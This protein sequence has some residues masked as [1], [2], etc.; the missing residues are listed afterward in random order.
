MRDHGV[1][2]TVCTPVKRDAQEIGS[3]YTLIELHD[4]LGH[5]N[6]ATTDRYSHANARR[7]QEMVEKL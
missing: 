1:E 6:I 3:Q 2:Q 5:A 4:I 7:M